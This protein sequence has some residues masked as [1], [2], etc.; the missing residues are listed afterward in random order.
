M[1]K[2]SK[3][4]M[5]GALST[6]NELRESQQSQPESS[7]D[8]YLSKSKDKIERERNDVSTK[9]TIEEI[10]PSRIFRWQHKDR[11]ENELGDIDELANT[12]LTIGQQQPCIVRPNKNG[13]E[14]EL[15]VGERRWLAAQRA[16]LKLKVIVKDINDKVASLIQAVENERREDLSDFSKGMS[17]AKKI[18][19]GLIVQQDLT[20]ILG[21]SKQ[22]VSRLLS[23]NKIPKALFDAI[24]DFRLVS[25]RTANELSRLA[26][27]NKEHLQI[28][29][30][31]APKIKKGNFGHT[32][33]KNAL[34][35]KLTAHEIKLTSNKKITDKNGHHLLTWRMDNNSVPSI[36]F[37]KD[38]VEQLTKEPDRME[39]V[40]E[41]LKKYL[42]SFV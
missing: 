12:F 30:N 16:N 38:I 5:C 1:S 11:P 20:D 18:E 9:N 34:E 13:K 8:K 36:H 22:Q 29:I 24:Q 3:D 21:I 31:L 32:S 4:N 26:A 33:I 7:I 42:S 14:Y 2:E 25:S 15:I 23:Y 28:L 10:E 35:K 17:Y 27:K 6:L 40:S 19:A 37:P 41:I 39:Q